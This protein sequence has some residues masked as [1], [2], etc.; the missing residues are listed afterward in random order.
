MHGD[1]VKRDLIL[2]SVA[3]IVAAGVAAVGAYSLGQISGFEAMGLMESSL[4][5]TRF[6][7]SGVMTSSATVLALMLTLLS[8]SNS[9][10]LRLSR[11][12]YRRVKGIALV[13]SISFVISVVFLLLLNIPLG[14]TNDRVPTG[15]YDNLYYVVL[16]TASGLGGIIISVVLMLYLTVRDMIQTIAG[17]EEEWLVHEQQSASEDAD[18]PDDESAAVAGIEPASWTSRL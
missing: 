8:F 7:A 10:E 17:D 15:W 6:L 18:E 9:A 11:L 1:P 12:H 2:A 13:V 4:P 16:A 5:T 3:G 14:E